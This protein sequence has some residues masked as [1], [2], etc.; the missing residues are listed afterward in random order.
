MKL[1]DF[2]ILF[3]DKLKFTIEHNELNEFFFWLIKFYCGIDRLNYVMDSNLVLNKIQETNLLKSIELIKSNM[4]IQYVIGETE[5]MNLRFLVNK[6][7]LIPRPETE[8]LV[9]WILMEKLNNKAILDVGTGSGCIAISLSKFSESSNVTA[10]DI[11]KKIIDL[12]K[13]NALLNEVEV[14]FELEDIRSVKSKKKFDIIVSNP[15]YICKKEKSKM[16]KNVLH[17]EPHI[18]LFVDD[19]DP[20]FF[21]SMILNH[22]K[23]NLKKNGKIFLEINE[24]KTKPVLKL[25]E[26]KGFT[27]IQL[28]Q[29]F[30]GKDRMVKA[31]I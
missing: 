3:Y 22:A 11:E 27:N 12:A 21:Y 17:F 23:K 25:L 18:A 8:E 10:W 26:N 15:P 20:L 13:K 28:K 16:K 2:K 19:N 7:V 9:S 1:S 30:R 5:F 4:P 29:D 14:F 24:N 31:F 6:N